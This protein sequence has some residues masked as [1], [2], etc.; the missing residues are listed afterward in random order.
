MA[1]ARSEGVEEKVGVLVGDL[2]RRHRP[3]GGYQVAMPLSEERMATAVCAASTPELTRLNTLGDRARNIP[4]YSSRRACISLR[5]YRRQEAPLVQEYRGILLEL[6]T[7]ATWARIMRSGRQPAKGS[8]Q[9]CDGR[10]F[11]V[12]PICR[13]HHDRPQD[14]FLGR[15]V[16][17]QPAAL[18]I[19]RLSDV[20]DACP[21]ITALA[22]ERGGSLFDLE[23]ARRVG[24]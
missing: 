5:R 15:D 24:T 20:T 23:P 18:E 11:S 10:D 12:E 14:V 3:V 6:V 9:C 4:S 2:G 1:S 22:K 19:E 13:A 16:G 21:G 17:I 7:T 8:R